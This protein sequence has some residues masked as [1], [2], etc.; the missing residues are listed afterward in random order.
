MSLLQ[1]THLPPGSIPSGARSKKNSQ[2]P[3]NS[4]QNTHL[5][6][7]SIPAGARRKNQSNV[8]S[9]TELR[10]SPQISSN[11]I[12]DSQHTPHHVNAPTVPD[13]TH[14]LSGQHV[15]PTA[16]QTTGVAN[17]VN[18]SIITPVPYD[19]TQ[20]SNGLLL[21]PSA[22]NHIGSQSYKTPPAGLSF[23]FLS[24]IANARTDMPMGDSAGQQNTE[25]VR[26]LIN[27]FESRMQN[28]GP[29]RETRQ[30]STVGADDDGEETVE[31]DRIL[32]LFYAAGNLGIAF[33]DEPNVI[34]YIK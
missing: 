31:E 17:G 1:N 12:P 34:S 26:D 3:L 30:P 32:G 5:P 28:G 13:A 2:T 9:T 19:G 10:N 27:D 6:P 16:F 29:V 21:P 23:Q 15:T 8:S 11:F 4:L 7:G 33:Y 14:L 25:Q 20:E 24:D 22:R 18:H